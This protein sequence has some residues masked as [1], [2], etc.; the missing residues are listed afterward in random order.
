MSA[1]GYTNRIR[2]QT[3]GRN[4]KVQYPGRIASNVNVLSAAVRLSP[5]YGVVSYTP[6]NFCNCKR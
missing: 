1:Q 3:E 6:V 5:N 2:V 4:N